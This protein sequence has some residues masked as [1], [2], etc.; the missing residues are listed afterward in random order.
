LNR[1]VHAVAADIEQLAALP[2]SDRVSDESTSFGGQLNPL[3]PTNP[4]PVR[5][6][7]SR[8]AEIELIINEHGA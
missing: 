4:L 3:V 2:S 6:E 8:S 5:V 1:A 7:T